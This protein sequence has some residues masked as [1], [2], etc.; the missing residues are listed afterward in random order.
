MQT[1]VPKRTSFPE[2]VKTIIET[3]EKGDSFSVSRLSQATNL[4]RRTVQ[5]A[6]DFLKEIQ[7]AFLE[8][9]LDVTELQGAKVI[10]IKK[11]VGMLSLPEHIQHLIIRMAYFPTPSREEEILVHAFTKK[12]LSAETAIRVS[13]SQLVD[14]LLKQGQL[15]ETENSRA[16][17]SIYLSDEGQIVAK[18]A[19]KLYPE[20]QEIGTTHIRRTSHGLKIRIRHTEIEIVGTSSIQENGE[21]LTSTGERSSLPLISSEN[22]EGIEVKTPK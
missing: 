9:R 8:M 22:H 14:K 2:A 18:G 1:V 7:H 10:Q 16:R 11:S 15:E 12:A 4:N 19:L 21:I 20:L 17:A 13:R 6:V 5:K 3:L